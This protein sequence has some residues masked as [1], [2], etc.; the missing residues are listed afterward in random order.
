MTDGEK[1]FSKPIIL[2]LVGTDHMVLVVDQFKMALITGKSN[3]KGMKQ[4]NE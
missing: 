3:L 4:M 2:I 1:S